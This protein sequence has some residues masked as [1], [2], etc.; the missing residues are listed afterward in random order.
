MIIT[1]DTEIEISNT[2][3]AIWDYANDPINW[4]ASNPSEHLG[5]VFYNDE[6]RPKEGT[7]FHQREMVAGVY[8]DLKGQIHFADYPRM[9]V[10]S[11]IAKYKLLG[12]LISVSAAE[13]GILR[14][15]VDGEKSHLSH[16]VYMQFSDTLWGKLWHWLFSSV[17]GAKKAVYDHTFRE[18]QFFKKHLE[19]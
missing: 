1:A 3:S 5:L 14:L 4:T 6:N 7:R 8:A 9:L 17:F 12:G 19:T 13:G 16:N 18:L 2:P 10:W 15:K 11:G